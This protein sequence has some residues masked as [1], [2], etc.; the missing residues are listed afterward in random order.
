MFQKYRIHPV[1][2]QQYISLTD[3]PLCFDWIYSVYVSMYERNGDEFSKNKEVFTE[4]V[5]AKLIKT[6]NNFPFIL[7]G[8]HNLNMLEHSCGTQIKLRWVHE[9][10]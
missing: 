5:C 6:L 9:A 8:K 4:F 1:N 2:T 3:R 10:R 7:M